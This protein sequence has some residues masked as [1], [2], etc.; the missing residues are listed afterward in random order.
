MRNDMIIWD[1][2]L[3]TVTLSSHGTVSVMFF[4]SD[5]VK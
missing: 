2:L 3:D 1:S 5:V 4:H